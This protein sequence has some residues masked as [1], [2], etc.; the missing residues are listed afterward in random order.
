MLTPFC[1][2]IFQ[3]L[4]ATVA[5]I[6]AQPFEQL[7]EALG[8]SFRA[9]FREV[10]L[11]WQPF[12]FIAVIIIIVIAMFTLSGLQVKLPFVTLTTVPA[13]P[14]N[15]QAQLRQ[16]ENQVRNMGE[17]VAQIN[18]VVHQREAVDN[19]PLQGDIHD[20]QTEILNLLETICEYHQKSAQLAVQG[21][22]SQQEQKV[23]GPVENADEG[24]A[25]EKPPKRAIIESNKDKKPV[26]NSEQDTKV[27][28]ED[29][30]SSEGT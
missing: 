15:F 14:G 26:Q 2:N 13:I 28:V 10:P 24:A 4:S 9:L 5:T 17:T 25:D 3:A 29:V 23:Y 22:R 16:L 19:A 11:Q 7:A 20:K 21:G 6:I 27:G 8:K 1:C 30:G 12:V 18:D